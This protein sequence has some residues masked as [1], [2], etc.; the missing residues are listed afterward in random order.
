MDGK[1]TGYRTINNDA[2]SPIALGTMRF[3]DKGTTESDLIKLFSILYN[4][5]GIN[6][7]HSSYEYNSYSLY[8]KAV[9]SFKKKVEL[10]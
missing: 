4:E 5:A 9:T 8:A 10:I 2:I 6:V 7:H 1:L 3:V